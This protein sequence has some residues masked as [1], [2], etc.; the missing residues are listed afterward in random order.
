MRNKTHHIVFLLNCNWKHIEFPKK[1][2]GEA[3]PIAFT[4]GFTTTCSIF[5]GLYC[6][7]ILLFTPMV[8]TSSAKTFSFVKFYFTIVSVVSVIGTVIAYAIASYQLLKLAIISNDEW[9]TQRGWYEIEA[10]TQPST[11]PAGDYYG[12]SKPIMEPG[13]NTEVVTKTPADIATCEQETRAR[14]ISQRNYETK[15]QSIGWLVR[16]TFFLFLFVTHYPRMMRLERGLW[17]DQ[18]HTAKTPSKS[19]RSPAKKK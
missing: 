16:G 5:I 13:T 18:P 10:C 12:V 7:F 2:Q 9:I 6:L 14:L 8:A 17:S 11:Y 4:S 19:T 3:F 15:E 1:Q